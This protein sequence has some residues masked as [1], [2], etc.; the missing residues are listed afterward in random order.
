[1]RANKIQFGI[2]T[3]HFEAVRGVI[4]KSFINFLRYIRLIRWFNVYIDFE[5][6]GRQSLI[7][8]HDRFLI[9]IPLGSFE[10]EMIEPRTCACVSFKQSRIKGGD[11]KAG[12]EIPLPRT[13]QNV[14]INLASRLVPTRFSFH[15]PIEIQISLWI[16]VENS[17]WWPINN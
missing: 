16:V 17:N 3:P 15:S 11:I 9:I 4:D 14:R 2:V 1:M 7:S 6:S 8:C 12:R 5:K 10:T 13:C